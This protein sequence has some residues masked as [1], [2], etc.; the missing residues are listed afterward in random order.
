MTRPE[1]VQGGAHFDQLPILERSPFPVFRRARLEAN[2]HRR[3]VDLIPLERQDLG[4]HAPAGVIGER[5]RV[6]EGFSQMPTNG[7][8]LLALEKPLP[9]VAFLE[10]RNV[11]PL[12][13]VSRLHRER[14]DPFQVGE[15]EADRGVRRAR[16]LTLS[17][18]RA[19]VGRRNR[20]QTPGTK[21]RGEMV[22]EASGSSLDF[23]M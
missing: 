19:H 14:K 23:G 3:A 17:D 6:I 5:D 9:D 12:Q 1:R 22:L 10:H 16:L 2:H 15:L 21:P 13:D 4:G 7:I 8:E 18:V 20:R 11:R